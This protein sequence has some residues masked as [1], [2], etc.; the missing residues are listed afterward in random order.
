MQ[1]DATPTVPELIEANSCDRD[2]MNDEPLDF[3]GTSQGRVA[4]HRS[5]GRVATHRSL[6]SRLC[7]CLF[8]AFTHFIHFTS[9]LSMS[10]YSIYVCV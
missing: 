5:Q 4:T 8:D 1:G 2:A 9:T 6:D 3:N 7:H 10:E